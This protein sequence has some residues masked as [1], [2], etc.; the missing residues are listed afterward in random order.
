MD[1]IIGGRCQGKLEFV[2]SIC[3]LSFDCVAKAKL[4]QT[5]Q[6]IDNLQAYIYH[7]MIEQSTIDEVIL[8][9]EIKEYL[10]K[11]PDSYLICDEVGGGVVP[12]DARERQYREIVGRV[13]CELAK[14]ARHVYRVYCGIGVE[15]KHA[16]Y[17]LDTTW[18]D[19]RK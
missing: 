8:L 9:H 14:Y 11:V 7:R 12:I 6:I 18:N 5:K 3:G 19:I 4:D 16:E 1:L 10:A 15:I 13:L 17:S 2:I